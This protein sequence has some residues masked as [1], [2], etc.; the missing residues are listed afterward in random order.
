MVPSAQLDL[1][2]RSVEGQTQK[3]VLPEPGRI[4]ARVL[5]ALKRVV[6]RVDGLYIPVL[7]GWRRNKRDARRTGAR[8][9]LFEQIARL[10]LSHG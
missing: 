5:A 1:F 2:P 4:A 8:N 10:R 3:R 7:V 9:C 6:K